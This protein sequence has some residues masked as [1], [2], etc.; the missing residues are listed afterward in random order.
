M[1]YRVIKKEKEKTLDIFTEDGGFVE[2]Y[3]NDT[4]YVSTMHSIRLTEVDKGDY[5][6]LWAK[7]SEGN[8][9]VKEWGENDTEDEMIQ[10]ALYWLVM[11]TP[12]KWEHD[13]KLFDNILKKAYKL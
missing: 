8:N 5:P 10:H 6:N 7:L 3:H 11:P 13:N 9:C 2:I 4:N 12:D 1:K